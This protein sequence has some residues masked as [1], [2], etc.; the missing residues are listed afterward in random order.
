MKEKIA[1]LMGG[2]SLEREVSFM[3][4]HRV[5][6]ALEE[7]GHEVVRLDVDENLVEN[8]KSSNVDLAYIALHG[9]YGE[10]GTMQ[11][12]LE[13]LDIP[14]TGP[15]VYSSRV[16]FDKALSKEIFMLEEIPTAPFFAL[17]SGTFKEM[18]G[19]ALL[20]N[21]IRKIGL[22]IVVKPA[23]QGSALGIKIARTKEE[24]PN[25]LI[26][27]LSYDDK[28]VVEKYIKGMEISISILGDDNPTP[29]PI[30]EIIP[31]KDFFDFESMYTMG[32]TDYFVPARI[33]DD[34]TKRVQEIAI[35]VHR[36]LRG[37][38]VS[39][40][41]LKIGEDNVPYV[42]ELNTSPGMTETSLLPMSAEAAG[43]SFSE[44]VEKLVGMAL[45][46]KIRA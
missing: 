35:K 42:L 17:S 18:G 5:A 27:A 3:S 6:E 37:R 26:A 28:V 41:D 2:R 23:C 13:I 29:L 24:L 30:V 33:S 19:S 34:M 25:A 21:I 9:K 12:L 40:I 10:D 14:Y 46:R 7:K 11:E 4:G 8:L 20:G 16:G 36:V 15:S 43:I 1:V 38:D 45:E 44:L 22:P 39:R 31:K 32:L